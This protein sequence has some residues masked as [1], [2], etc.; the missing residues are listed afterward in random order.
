MNSEQQCCDKSKHWVDSKK[1]LPKSCTVWSL[2]DFLCSFLSNRHL[3]TNYSLCY[4]HGGG[5]FVIHFLNQTICQGET[6]LSSPE[7][8]VFFFFFLHNLVIHIFLQ[9]ALLTVWKAQVKLIK[10][11]DGWIKQNKTEHTLML[12][13]KNCAFPPATSQNVLKNTFYLIVYFK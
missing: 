9:Q 8:S 11:I 3:A 12:V 2:Y 5:Q 4:W 6:W 1:L 10:M 7:I 13:V